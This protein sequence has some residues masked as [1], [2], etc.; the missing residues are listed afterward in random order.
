MRPY[1]YNVRFI[2]NTR[3]YHSGNAFV[4]TFYDTDTGEDPAT[5]SFSGGPGSSGYVLSD[6]IYVEFLASDCSS[7]KIRDFYDRSGS[8]NFVRK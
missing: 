2:A 7:I 4:Q 3:A 1:S 5:V 6:K 8:V